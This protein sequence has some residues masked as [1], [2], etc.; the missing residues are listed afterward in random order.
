MRSTIESL[1]TEAFPRLRVGI[2]R[3]PSSVDPADYVLQPF[4]EEDRPVLD[5]AVAQAVAAVECWLSEGIVVAMDR[6]NRPVLAASD[7]QERE[8]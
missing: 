7:L 4:D 2:G 3:P 1:G 8:A 5:Q 6:F